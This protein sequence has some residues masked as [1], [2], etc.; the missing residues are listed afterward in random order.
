MEE[1]NLIPMQTLLYLA[2]IVWSC[3]TW[4]RSVKFHHIRMNMMPSQMSLL[5]EVPDQHTNEEYIL[6]FNEALWMGDTL[7]HSLIN[8]NQLHAYGTLVQDNPYHTDPVGITPP[9]PP[10]P[11]HTHTMTLKFC[12]AL[13]GP[14]SMPTPAP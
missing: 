8:P 5:S 1:S 13:L 2:Q 4:E 7:A 6:I 14:S 11:T 10:P 3:I 9:P 12:S